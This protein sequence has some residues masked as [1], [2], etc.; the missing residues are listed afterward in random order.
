MG[1]YCRRD[2]SNFCAGCGGLLDEHKLNANY[3]D[4]TDG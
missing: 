4:E 2:N 3:F 1:V